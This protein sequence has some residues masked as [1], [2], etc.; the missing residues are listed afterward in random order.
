M[1]RSARNIGAFPL[2][3]NR[4]NRLYSLLSSDWDRSQ[5]VWIALTFLG[6]GVQCGHVIMS[7]KSLVPGHSVVLAVFCRWPISW[8]CSWIFFSFTP[9]SMR[10]RTA[11]RASSFGRRSADTVVRIN[12]L[13]LQSQTDLL[14]QSLVKREVY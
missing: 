8:Y 13:T 2:S 5:S 10:L 7:S 6:S 9:H 12:P 3:S 11:C 1:A 14:Y 4:Q